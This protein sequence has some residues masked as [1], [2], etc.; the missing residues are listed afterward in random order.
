MLCCG[1]CS[2]GH[3]DFVLLAKKLLIKQES[4]YLFR[5]L[6]VPYATL[7]YRRKTSENLM[8]L[9]GIEMVH[10]ERMGYVMLKVY[11]L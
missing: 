7:F 4:T 9:G 8:L 1:N 5:F 11:L 6:F 10:W 3:I 2:Y